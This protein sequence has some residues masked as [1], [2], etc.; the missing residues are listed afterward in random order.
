MNIRVI[1]VLLVVLAIA[2]VSAASYSLKQS[3]E[4]LNN[5]RAVVDSL[6]NQART[7][8]ASISEMRTAQVAYVARGQ[9]EDFWIGR[10]AK[11]LPGVQQQM[12][13]F[14]SQLGSAAA[15]AAFEPA[16]AAIENFRK[17]D[18]RAQDFVKTDNALLASDLIFSDGLE[19]TAMATTQL[20]AALN[21]ELQARQAAA[22][23]QR[24]MQLTM[25]G[26]S[27]AGVLLIMVIL[28]F[29]GG[30][31]KIAEAV[32]AA[33]PAPQQA[34][35]VQTWTAPAVNLAHAARLCT[36]LAC[37]VDS[38]QLPG[39]LERTAGVLDSAG[40]IVWV[41]DPA[42][43]SLKAAMSFGY[44]D[45]VLARMGNIHRDANNAVAAAFRLGEMR[46][47]DGGASTSGALVMPLL[48]PDGCI[49]ALSA[50]MKHGSEKDEASQALAAIFAAQLATLVTPPLAA[51]Q[52]KA[53]A[54]A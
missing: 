53:T 21:E 24:A 36:D 27:A 49:G 26:G 40:I 52:V 25:L 32:P 50:E 48:T 45:Q 4:A 16:L 29:A 18:H 38:K 33:V 9:G 47:V 51:A 30:S 39:L 28:A 37:V 10:V 35:P 11:L 54:H 7:L 22:A 8:A 5:D 46:M 31:R 20:E 43:D 23:S 15:Q 13:D 2:V 14:G 41:A 42:S 6:R 1:R 19:A 3:D 44:S 12:V 17:L 34:E